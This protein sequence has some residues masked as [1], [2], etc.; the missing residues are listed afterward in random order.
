MAVGQ[1]GPKLGQYNFAMWEWLSNGRLE[2]WR[3]GGLDSKWPMAPGCHLSELSGYCILCWY[4]TNICIHP[5][6][7][8]DV[9]LI[10]LN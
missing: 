2:V 6:S 4:G 1:C 3:S 7:L 9:S 5:I 10:V 8:K